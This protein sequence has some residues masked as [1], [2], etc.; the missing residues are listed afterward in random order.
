MSPEQARGK[1][2]DKRADIWAFGCCLFE[3][4]S[5]KTAFLGETVT[6][7]IAKIVER[8]PDWEALAK[9][10]PSPIHR[11]P[12]RCLQKDAN[13]R[14]HDIADAR[15]EIDQAL[16]EPTGVAELHR[17][18]ARPTALVA[19]AAVAIA[20]VSIALWSLIRT[21]ERPDRPVV[22]S[23]LPLAPALELRVRGSTPSV[24]TLPT[25]S[26]S[27]SRHAAEIRRSFMCG[28]SMR[29]SRNP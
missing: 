20:A 2:V 5:G 22:R 6:D 3:A 28:L 25:G 27:P 7:T 18:G 15:L 23:V 29:R 21:S 11:L 14:L 8:E 16:T 10:T 19:L 17:E 12:H 1:A 24:T 9:R 13:Q 26:I 4:L